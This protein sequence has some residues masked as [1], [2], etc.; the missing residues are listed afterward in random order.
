MGGGGNWREEGSVHG[1]QSSRSKSMDKKR[2]CCLDLH[3][4]KRDNA[5]VGG[6]QELIS[7]LITQRFLMLN[8]TG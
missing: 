8:K 1:H 7:I 4:A 3:E 6:K 2:N 5:E